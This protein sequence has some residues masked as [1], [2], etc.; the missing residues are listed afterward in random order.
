M[1]TAAGRRSGV[2]RECPPS[3]VAA[4]ATT[5]A[6]AVAATATPMR[7][8]RYTAAVGR[9][10]TT[11]AGRGGV[12][13]RRSRGG[14]G[15]VRRGAGARVRSSARAVAPTVRWWRAGAAGRCERVA[16]VRHFPVEHADD[17]R[18]A[19]MKDQIIQTKIAMYQRRRS[20][21]W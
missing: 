1:T 13:T 18:L 15:R 17:A 3:A 5:R 4:C 14:G 21:R 8:R 20:W 6:S 2:A 12:V 9:G 10:R 11:T 19:V 16:E 7:R